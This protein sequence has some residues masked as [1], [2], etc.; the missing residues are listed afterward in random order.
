MTAIV[1]QIIINTC[2][3]NFDLASDTLWS[4]HFAKSVHKKLDLADALRHPSTETGPTDLPESE[5]HE[6]CA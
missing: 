3:Y 5:R 4:H 6:R 2:R 1:L